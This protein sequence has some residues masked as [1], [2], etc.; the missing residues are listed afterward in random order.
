MPY[1]DPEKQRAA[2]KRYKLLHAASCAKYA[3]QWR[4]EHAEQQRAYHRAYK[5]AHAE[6][7]RQN[8]RKYAATEKGKLAIRQ[9]KKKRRQ[10]ADGKSYR[11]RSHWRRGVPSKNLRIKLMLAQQ[12][13]CKL[14]G[15]DLKLSGSHLDHIIPA[16]KG[17]SNLDYNFQLLCPR[18]NYAKRDHLMVV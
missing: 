14:C 15:I 10:K 2:C 5:L 17:G 3:K 16:S 18:C 12:G 1:K 8:S 9:W 7:N 13:I 4:K 11:E 6:Q